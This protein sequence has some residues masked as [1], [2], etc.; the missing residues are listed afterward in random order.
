MVM[1]MGVM[2]FEVAIG[3]WGS[4]RRMWRCVYARLRGDDGWCAN[5]LYVR[6]EVG[7]SL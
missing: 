3:S 4:E 7:Y 1:V 2:V 6:G 5:V